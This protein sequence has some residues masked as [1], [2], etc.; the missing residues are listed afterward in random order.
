MKL[1]GAMA[2]L[3]YATDEE[4]LIFVSNW[5]R[6]APWRGDA[7][8]SCGLF[9]GERRQKTPVSRRLAATVF[10]SA[11]RGIIA[12]CA[13]SAAYVLIYL[14][15]KSEYYALLIGSVTA[16]GAIV[17]TMHVT[18]SLDWYGGRDKA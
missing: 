14:L 17:V 13:F 10:H 3:R 15:M 11:W 7:E 2:S 12:I 8:N 9:Q 1:G 16:F 18:R 4:A 6:P 5:A